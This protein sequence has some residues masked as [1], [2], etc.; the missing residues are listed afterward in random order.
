MRLSRAIELNAGDIVSFVGA[1][2][3]T[4]AMF[5]LAEELVGQN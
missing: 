5:R 4:S 1:G 3:K 2:G